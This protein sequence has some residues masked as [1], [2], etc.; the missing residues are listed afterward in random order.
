MMLLPLKMNDVIFDEAAMFGLRAGVTVPS[1]GPNGKLAMMSFAQSSSYDMPRK[2]VKYLELSA[3]NFRLVI[4]K[5][6]ASRRVD[7]EV[8]CLS[9][10]EKECIIWISRGRSSFVIGTIL[11]ISENTV[12]FHIKKAMN[13]LNCTSRTAAV[14]KA[15]KL[16]IVDI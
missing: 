11:G 4:E 8:H 15:L 14:V 13:K 16:G 5:Y 12:N 3:F 1:H 9:A 6:E 2:I 10:R 7:Q